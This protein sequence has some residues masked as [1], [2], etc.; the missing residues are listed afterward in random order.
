VFHY[1]PIF[2]R[3]KLNRQKKRDKKKFFSCNAK[4]IDLYVIDITK[5]KI[6][7]EET[8]QPYLNEIINIINDRIN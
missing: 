8:C 6:V 4:G 1:K 3:A 7:T 5:Q 2:G